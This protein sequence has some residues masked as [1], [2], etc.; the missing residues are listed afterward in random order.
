ML[1]FSRVKRKLHASEAAL[2][3]CWQMVGDAKLAS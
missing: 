2:I 1:R 3:T